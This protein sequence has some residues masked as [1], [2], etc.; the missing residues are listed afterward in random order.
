MIFLIT[1]STPFSKEHAENVTEILRKV[2]RE[3]IKPSIFEANDLPNIEQKST[4]ESNLNPTQ[5]STNETSHSILNES[6]STPTEGSE[7][8]SNPSENTD[9]SATE[10]SSQT[11]LE[12]ISTIAEGSGEKFDFSSLIFDSTS[13]SS[14]NFSEVTET[15]K[16]TELTLQF[17]YKVVNYTLMIQAQQK[18]IA[19]LSETVRDLEN[20]VIKLKATSEKEST[21]SIARNDKCK[22]EFNNLMYELKAAKKLI[23]MEKYSKGLRS[24]LMEFG[25]IDESRYDYFS[26]LLNFKAGSNF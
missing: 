15:D 4:P 8:F 12:S 13:D 22:I 19:K 16:I 3:A 25:V 17:H 10:E 5:Y 26:P 11:F 2:T 18:L 23:G 1:V 20:D 6:I 9:L 14:V 7:E 24:K 21:E